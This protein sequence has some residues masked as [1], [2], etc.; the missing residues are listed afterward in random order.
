MAVLCDVYAFRASGQQ[1]ESADLT[2]WPPG[3]IQIGGFV[4]GSHHAP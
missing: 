4:Q 1:P 2:L 3:T